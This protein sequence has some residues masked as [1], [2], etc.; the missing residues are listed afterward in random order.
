MTPHAYYCRAERTWK[1]ESRLPLG[2][3]TFAPPLRQCWF[4]SHFTTSTHCQFTDTTHLIILSSL[5]LNTVHPD[6]SR[7][8]SG[9][10]IGIT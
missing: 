3:Q 1:I 4:D 6:K 8:A 9:R 7:A 5:S 10:V 2:R